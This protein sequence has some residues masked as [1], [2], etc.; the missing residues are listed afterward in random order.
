MPLASVDALHVRLMDVAVRDATAS[1]EGTLGAVVSLD[2]APGVMVPAL[3]VEV[4]SGR[5]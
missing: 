1:P 4:P 2:G 3:N 5:K